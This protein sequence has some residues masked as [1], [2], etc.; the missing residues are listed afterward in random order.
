MHRS[1]WRFVVVFG[2]DAYANELRQAAIGG[3]RRTTSTVAAQYARPGWRTSTTVA[4]NCAA[5]RSRQHV[6]CISKT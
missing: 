1:I 5:N 4:A 6:S 2:S 3:G